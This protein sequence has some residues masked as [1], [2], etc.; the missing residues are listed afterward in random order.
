MV[1]MAFRIGTVECSNN[2]LIWFIPYFPS[3]ASGQYLTWCSD[4][5]LL[6][7][8]VSADEPTELQAII[9]GVI[10][11]AFGNILQSNKLGSK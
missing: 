1:G 10:L 2:K 7:S 4:I 8:T 11:L 3:Y 9:S 5:L 6:L